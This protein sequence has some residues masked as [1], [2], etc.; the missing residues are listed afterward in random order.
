MVPSTAWGRA[1]GLLVAVLGAVL[2]WGVQT[3]YPVATSSWG[4]QH[5]TVAETSADRGSGSGG[6]AGVTAPERAVAAAPPELPE[7]QAPASLPNGVRV[8]ASTGFYAVEGTDLRG[9]LASLRQNGPSDGHGTWAASTAWAFRWSYRPVVNG[10]CRV[11]TAHV[12]LDLTYT[13]PQWAVPPDA[14]P[15]AVPAWQA[16]LAHVELHEQGHREIAE[17]AAAD[18]VRSLEG[19]LASGSCDQLSASARAVV[20]E[21]LARHAELQVAYDQETGHGAT[22]GAVLTVD[23]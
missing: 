21:R 12:D 11:A 2:V 14:A 16:Y 20:A 9:L 18:L 17:A 4:E 23:R 3:E 7:D 22:Q 15:A 13:Y 8:S 5:G 19:L 1:A 10:G 6:A